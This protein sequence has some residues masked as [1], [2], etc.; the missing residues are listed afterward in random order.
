MTEIVG[1]IGQLRRER[2]WVRYWTFEVLSGVRDTK[3]RFGIRP[4]GS[5]LM[6]TVICGDVK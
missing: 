5:A 3:T 6:I 1:E 4:S 2:F